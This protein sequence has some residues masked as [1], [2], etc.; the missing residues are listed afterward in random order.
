MRLRITA[1]ETGR[2]GAKVTLLPSSLPLSIVSSLRLLFDRRDLA[3]RRDIAMVYFAENKMSV[4]S[5][6][7]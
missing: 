7:R 1:K 2:R 6:Q 5:F 3:A 4:E